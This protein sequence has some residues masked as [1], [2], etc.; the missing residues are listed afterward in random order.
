MSSAGHSLPKI[1]HR[2]CLQ[3]LLGRQY[4][5]PENLET[6]VMQN[7]WDKHGAL[8]SMRKWGIVVK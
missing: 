6:M 1:L 8:W 7:L 2:H 5:T 4:I 3:F